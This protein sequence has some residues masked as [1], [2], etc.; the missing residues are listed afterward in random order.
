[1]SRFAFRI[2]ESRLRG[3][4]PEEFWEDE[5]AGFRVERFAM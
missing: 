5:G 3:V 1:V 2:I 4:Q